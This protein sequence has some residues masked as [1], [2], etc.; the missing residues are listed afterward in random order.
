MLR[1]DG[2]SGEDQAQPDPVG[3]LE[4]NCPTEVVSPQKARGVG[5]KESWL[6]TLAHLRVFCVCAQCVFM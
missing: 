6:H 3:S 5:A 4:H 2:V 1:K